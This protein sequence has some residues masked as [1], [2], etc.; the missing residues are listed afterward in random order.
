MRAPRPRPRPPRRRAGFTFVELLVVMVVIGLLAMMA[1]LRVRDTRG[2]AY[3]AA[4]LANLREMRVAE[5]LYVQEHDAY[6]AD[7]AMLDFAPARG[8][9]VAITEASAAGWA[10]TIAHPGARL[11]HCAL[12]VGRA[13]PPEPAT[14]E[15]EIACR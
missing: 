2:R 11:H 5:E 9:V 15:G 14:T 12:F 10:A 7:V 1:M 13:T 4:L 6:T 8:A 3:D